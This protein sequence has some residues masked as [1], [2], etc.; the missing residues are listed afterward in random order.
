MVQPASKRLLT[1]AA[2]ASQASN[3]ATPLGAALSA[4]YAS[5][6]VETTKLDVAAAAASYA[7]L[8]SAPFTGTPTLNGVPLVTASNL[9]A[10]GDWSAPS[11]LATGGSW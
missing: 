5:K 8:A 4:T 9:A 2:A 10:A 3:N 11:T 1:E 6:G 7:P